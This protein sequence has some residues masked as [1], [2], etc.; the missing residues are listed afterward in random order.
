[1]K[2]GLKL[3]DMPPRVRN[4]RRM[5]TRKHTK[6]CLR[7]DSGQVARYLEA[8]SDEAW[9]DFAEAYRAL[10]AQRVRE[11]PTPFDDIA[12]LATDEDVAIGCSC[13]TA[14]N[15]DVSKCHTWLALEFMQGRYDGL[16]IEFPE[17]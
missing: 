3:D 13:P 6:H 9:D 8:P 12:R 15:P 17:A 14:T 11:D 2:R 16:E 7:P 4:A 5:D 10:I 1:M